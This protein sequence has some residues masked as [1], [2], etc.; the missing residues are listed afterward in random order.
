MR[1]S[2]TKLIIAGILATTM[3]F[4]H[5]LAPAYAAIPGVDKGK[6]GQ[7]ELATTVPTALVGT[8]HSGSLAASNFYNHKTQEWGEPSGRGVFLVVQA[9]GGYRFGAGEVIAATQYFIYQEGT[10]TIVDS[11][12]VLSAQT[13][14]EYSRDASGAPRHNQ[15]AA[16]GDE[17]QP[18][19]LEYQIVM[20]PAD[21]HQP[22][23]VLT[24]DQGERLTLRQIAQ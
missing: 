4:E 2:I 23:L 21:S 5:Q 3:G 12:L 13:A 6:E 1:T 20:D 11:H 17:R 19:T 24:N 16:T 14:S 10:I 8:W 15:R 22:S 7:A 9:D 18:A